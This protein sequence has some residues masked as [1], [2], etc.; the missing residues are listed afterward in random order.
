MALLPE[1]IVMHRREER[2]VT[3]YREKIPE[4]LCILSAKRIHGEVASSPRIHVRIQAP[5]QHLHERIS[6]RIIL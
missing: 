6:H 5:L 4:I 3:I 2:Q 1:I